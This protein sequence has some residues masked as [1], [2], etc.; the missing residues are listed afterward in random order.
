M[1]ESLSTSSATRKRRLPRYVIGFAFAF[2][3]VFGI[4]NSSPSG[5]QFAT[6]ANSWNSYGWPSPWLRVHTYQTLGFVGD[7]WERHVRFEGAEVTSWSACFVS[8]AACGS[9]FAALV[10][11]LALAHRLFF[12]SMSHSHER[13]A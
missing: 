8:V 10:A 3:V 5:S 13:N 6:G 7:H 1:N 2:L 12:S 11:A 9:I 4:T